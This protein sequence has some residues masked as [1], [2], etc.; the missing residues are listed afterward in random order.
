MSALAATDFVILDTETT[1]LNPAQG[2]ALVEIAGQRVR[3]TQ[4]IDQFCQVINPGIPCT[5]GAASVHGMT[6]EY[7]FVHGKP[8]REVIPAF[9]K[10]CDQ[11]TLVGHN[12]IK[13][14]L[15]FINNHL[16]QLGLQPMTNPVIDTLHLARK[17]LN[18]PSYKLGDVASHYKVSY[19]N[20][21]RALRDVEITREIFYHLAG[22]KNTGRLF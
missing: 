1:G 7:I 17:K 2:D 22:F 6:E 19:S 15:E 3:G 8:L 11:A 14:D 10:F 20:A 5:N 16:R 4:V 9:I 21:H 13:F 18:L 12:I